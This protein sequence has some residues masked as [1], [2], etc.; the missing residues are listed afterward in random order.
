MV[1]ALAM[2]D[3]PPWHTAPTVCPCQYLPQRLD[4]ISSH[5]Y[6]IDAKLRSIMSEQQ[7]IDTDVQAIEGDVAAIGAAVTAIQAEIAALQQQNPALDLTGLNQAV[8]DLATATAGV[9]GLEP[10]PAT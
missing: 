2:N 5:L 3:R 10:P 6:R 1:E 9:Q 7:D 4:S 8:A